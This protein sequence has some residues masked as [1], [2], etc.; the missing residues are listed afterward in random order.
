MADE[1]KTYTSNTLW[2]DSTGVMS[3][4]EQTKD[5]QVNWLSYHYVDAEGNTVYPFQSKTDVD[6]FQSR[7]NNLFLNH[8]N[9]FQAFLNS[10]LN[11]SVIDS[12]KDVEDFLKGISDDEAMTLLTFI[13]SIELASG[14]LNIR[15]SEDYPGAV[16]AVETSSDYNVSNSKI[17]PETGAIKIV[18]NFE[19]DI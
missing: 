9:D 6:K 10:K 14:T 8:Y 7:L 19:R 17:D 2:N 15:M 18:F 16:E 12:W 13:T 11:P 1:N 5:G 4:A 3:Y